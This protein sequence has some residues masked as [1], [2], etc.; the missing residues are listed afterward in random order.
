MIKSKKAAEGVVWMI[1]IGALL[2]I[3][4]FIYSGVWKTLFSRSVSGIQDSDG[5]S[6]PNIKDSCPCRK[7]VIENNGCPAGQKPLENENI[8]CISQ[9]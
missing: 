8:Q 9:K 6:V 5:D 4:L 2:L 1:V 7:G 3:F